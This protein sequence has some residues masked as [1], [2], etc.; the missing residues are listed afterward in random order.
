MKRA[1]P[2]NRE[3]LPRSQVQ[4]SVEHARLA[5]REAAVLMAPVAL[6][7]L[8][9]G[10]SYPAFAD[11]LKAVFLHAARDELERSKVSPT[12]SALSMLSGVH[13]KDVRAYA[14]AP[15]TAQPQPRPPLSSQVLTR[16]LTDARYRAADGT[17]HALPRAGT[18]RS[19]ESLCRELSNDVHPRTVLDELL[20]LGL[21]AL[22]GERVVALATSFVPS[23]SLAEM[24]ALF[25]AN[26]SD[27]IAAAVSNLT[28][29]APKYLE[30]S[31]YADGLTPASI[32]RLHLAAREAWGHAFRRWWRR[33]ASASTT[34]RR[35]DND[36]ACASACISS[37][38]PRRGSRARRQRAS[39]QHTEHDSQAT[40]DKDPTMK[41]KSSTHLR[42]CRAARRLGALLTAAA[43]AACGGG[44]G[45]IGSGGTGS[46]LGVAVGTVNGFGSVIVDGSVASTIGGAAVVTEIAPGVDAN[47]DVKLGD[48]VAVEYETPGV[49]RWC[50]SRPRCPAPR[51]SSPRRADSRSSASR[52]RSTSMARSARSPSSAAATSSPQTCVPATPSRCTACWCSRAVA[53]RSWPPASTSWPRAGLPARDR[54]REPVRRCR[55]DELRARRTDGRRHGR[56]HRARQHRLGQRPDGDRARPAGDADH[57]GAGAWRVQAPQVRISELRDGGLDDYVSGSVAHLD[58]QAKTFTLGSLRVDYSVAALSPAATP[59]ADGQY[60]LVRGAVGADGALRASSLTMRDTGSDTESELRGNISGYDGATLRFSVRDVSVDATGAQLEGC[61]AAGLANGLFVEVEGALSST[62]VVARKLH[63][64]DEPAGAAV[65]REGV[66]AVVN[67]AGMSFSLATEHGPVVDVKWTNTTYFGGVTPATLANKPV[68]VEGVLAGNNVLIASKVKRED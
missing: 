30:Q 41:S 45:V 56:Q 40:P 36:C 7:L 3:S 13:R 42:T 37:A 58:A 57:G 62:G 52:S 28:M 66:A 55:R 14:L 43:L 29:N 60:V 8:R 31:V 16:W 47:A 38:N 21:V 51:A 18:R 54:H 17:P 34:T 67:V 10:V 5:L 50:A 1:P 25:S 15:A 46:P 61:P 27:H 22:D 53:C 26:A 20:R 33:R 2:E 49:A 19:F 11:M 68:H 44:D 35:H 39:R 12:Q 48:R 6:W 4:P 59:L 24:T 64:E 32:E 63:C 23:S 65:E 9:H